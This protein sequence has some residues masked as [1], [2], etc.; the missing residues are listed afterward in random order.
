MV[1]I[2]GVSIKK[3]NFYDTSLHRGMF[4]STLF[5]I[6]HT[7]IYLHFC[8][9]EQCTIPTFSSLKVFYSIYTCIIYLLFIFYILLFYYLYFLFI[10]LYIYVHLCNIYCVLYIV[11]ITRVLWK[12]LPMMQ[13]W[14]RKNSRTFFI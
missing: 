14:L 1:L 12:V 3:T 9:A 5:T 7:T 6:S 4:K 2:M 10:Y 13:R 8:V 11:F